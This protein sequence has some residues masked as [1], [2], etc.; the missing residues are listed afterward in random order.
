MGWVV[1]GLA[2]LMVGLVYAAVKGG[3]R[4][5]PVPARMRQRPAPAGQKARPQTSVPQ[6]GE[7]GRFCTKCGSRIEGPSKFCPNCGAKR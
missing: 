6:G 3:S 5:K 4:R 7:A 2:V 1:V